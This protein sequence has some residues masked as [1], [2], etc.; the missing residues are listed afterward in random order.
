MT[1]RSQVAGAAS[2]ALPG[3]ARELEL[4]AVRAGRWVPLA[5]AGGDGVGSPTEQ[6]KT[7]CQSAHLRC[8]K[9]TPAIPPAMLR[10]RNDPLFV[11]WF[12]DSQE[13][14][15]SIACFLWRQGN[16]VIEASFLEL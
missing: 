14:L 9:F 15:P 12:C 6:P 2:A 10:G 1:C 11:L 3:P 5:A 16:A 7:D 4:G 8:V 13:N